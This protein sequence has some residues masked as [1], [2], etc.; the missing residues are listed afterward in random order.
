M[1]FYSCLPWCRLSYEFEIESPVLFDTLNDVLADYWSDLQIKNFNLSGFKRSLINSQ[2]SLDRL[3]TDS[4][5]NRICLT[6]KSL[7]TGF[8]DINENGALDYLFGFGS[9]GDVLEIPVDDSH[10]EDVD[11]SVQQS[12]AYKTAISHAVTDIQKRFTVF[13]PIEKVSCIRNFF[14]FSSNESSRVLFF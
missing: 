2:E 12:E 10:F 7:C 6:V 1:S 3:L 9:H 8:S 14:M 11:I 5:D 13:G 4:K